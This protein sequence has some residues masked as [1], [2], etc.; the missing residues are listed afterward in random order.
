M[1][2]VLPLVVIATVSI[3]K[4]PIHHFFRIFNDMNLMT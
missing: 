2:D 4:I 1:Y 3:F